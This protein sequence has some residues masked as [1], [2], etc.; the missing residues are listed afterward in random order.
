M[1]IRAMNKENPTTRYAWTGW[2]PDHTN[3]VVQFPTMKLLGI[4][5]TKT[6]VGP[7]IFTL[8]HMELP[9]DGAISGRYDQLQSLKNKL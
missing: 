6:D 3:V 8:L 2:C 9:M 4:T 5:L 7:L 1:F